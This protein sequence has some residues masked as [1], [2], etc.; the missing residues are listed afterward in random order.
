V[1]SVSTP[2]C[3]S[4]KVEP[5]LS[6]IRYIKLSTHPSQGERRSS[7]FST[8]A[9]AGKKKKNLLSPQNRVKITKVNNKPSKTG[10][11]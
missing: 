6:V 5:N 11:L 8:I 2:R 4:V 3:V 10:I 9:C 1:R 7:N